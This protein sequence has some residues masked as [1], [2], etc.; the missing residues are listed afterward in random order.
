[1]CQNLISFLLSSPVKNKNLLINWE[2]NQNNKDSEYLLKLIVSIN[3]S[4]SNNTK[5]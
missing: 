2:K 5:A 3:N 1:M 4:G